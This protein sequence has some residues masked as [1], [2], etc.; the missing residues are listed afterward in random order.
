VTRS[1][2][3]SREPATGSFPRR[4]LLAAAAVVAVAAA[5]AWA[6]WRPSPPM[7]AGPAAGSASGG[8]STPAEYASLVGNWVRPDGGYVLSVSG[9]GA[10]GAATASYF[11]PQ[12]IRVA[13]AEVRREGDHVGLFVEFDHPSYP[14]STY[15]LAYDRATD[16]LKGVYYQ[17]LQQ[18]RYEVEFVRQR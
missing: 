17:A 16:T 11:N 10:D 3:T 5:L 4:R 1:R 6:T 8:G 14:G 15:T 9:V 18:A 7:P 12:P 2:R 13:R